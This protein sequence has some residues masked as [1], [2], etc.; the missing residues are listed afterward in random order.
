MTL[1]QRGE[2]YRG[3]RESLTRRKV[4]RLRST[5]KQRPDWDDR[6]SRLFAPGLATATVPGPAGRSS[7]GPSPRPSGTGRDR[8][9]LARV[10][11]D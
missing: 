11:G 3:A 1:L 8:P 6:I 9:A 2:D 10:A 5:A 4:S 7:P